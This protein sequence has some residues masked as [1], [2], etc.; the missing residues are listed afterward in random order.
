[1]YCSEGCRSSANIEY[2]KLECCS[3]DKSNAVTKLV[4]VMTEM[5]D[6]KMNDVET[7]LKENSGEKYL[8]EMDFSDREIATKDLLLAASYNS[9]RLKSAEGIDMRQVEEKDNFFLKWVEKLYQKSFKDLLASNPK[10]STN[11]LEDDLPVIFTSMAPVSDCFYHSCNPNLLD[12]LV[13]GRDAF[14]VTE[15]IKAGKELFVTYKPSYII[16]SNVERQLELQ[17]NFNFTCSCI[18]CEQ[19]FPTAHEMGENDEKSTFLMNCF[20]MKLK[21]SIKSMSAE[22]IELKLHEIAATI[23]SETFPS[24]IKAFRLEWLSIC[25]HGLQRPVFAFP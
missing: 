17:Q 11:R 18:A 23:E 21:N 12:V 20:G 10:L 24:L 1:M 22:E 5:F 7:F 15:P 16:H 9:A 25:L 19:N 13:N 8:M 14:F 3:K 6:G 4:H 2:H